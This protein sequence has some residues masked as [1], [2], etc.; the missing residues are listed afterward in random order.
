MMRFA[1]EAARHMAKAEIIEL[2]HDRQ[3]RRAERHRGAHRRADGEAGGDVAD[4]LG[5]P[6]RAS[7][8]TRRSSSA[9][10]ARR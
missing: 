7:S 10:S 1:A 3:A 6:A 2:H 9:T 8:P 5:A 4:P